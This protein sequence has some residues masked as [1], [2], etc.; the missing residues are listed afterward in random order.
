MPKLSFYDSQKE[1]S[2]YDRISEENVSVNNF[3]P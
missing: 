3:A 2:I 1:S